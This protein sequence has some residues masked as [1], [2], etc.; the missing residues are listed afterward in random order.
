MYIVGIPKELKQNEQ[1]VSLIP[2]DV[3]KLTAK[4]IEVYFQRDAGNLANNYNEEYMNV[5]A[6]ICDT[7]EDIYKNCNFIIKVKEPQEYEY[8]LINSSHTIFTFFHFA[9]NDKLLNAMINSGS[10][11]YTYE[12]IKVDGIYP[13]LSLMSKIAGEQSMMDALKF[14]FKD[15]IYNYNTNISIFGAG[16]AGLA[17]MHIALNSGFTNINL[18][19]INYEKLKIIK[20]NY[21]INIY[22]MNDENLRKLVKESDIIIG[23][24]YN[25]GKKATKLITNEL[26]DTM[27]PNSIIMDIAI[28]QGG[29]T[30]QSQ[31]K[32]ITNPIIKYKNTNI[33]CIPNIPSCLP[34]QASKLLS[35][36]IIKYVMAICNN[37]EI[38]PELEIGKGLSIKNYNYYN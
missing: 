37:S 31:P 4:G 20:D 38:Y 29:I 26:L 18:L 14:K 13:I 23:S 32:S 28:D 11:C 16:N 25:T 3:A 35:N 12:T 10:T 5:G 19:D 24:I 2:E 21:D 36:A 22:Q 34:E 33:S 7:I 30:E 17:A 1:R 6:K 15:T 27:K 9:S 8:K